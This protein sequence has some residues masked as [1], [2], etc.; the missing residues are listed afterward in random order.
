MKKKILILTLLTSAFITAHNDDASAQYNGPA[1]GDITTV[2]SVLANGK[3]DQYVRLVGTIKGQASEEKYMF[4]DATGEIR[5]EIDR[6]VFKDPVDENTKVEIRGE[7]EK[8]F[9]ESAEIDVESL[10]VQK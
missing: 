7:I 9:M 4:A 2:S 6:N 5:V 3:D 10:I 1:A 8:D